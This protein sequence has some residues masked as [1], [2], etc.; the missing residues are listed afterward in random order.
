[1]FFYGLPMSEIA[2]LLYF[3]YLTSLSLDLLS[4]LSPSLD[5]PS[6]GLSTHGLSSCSSCSSC[7]S[8]CVGSPVNG[9]KCDI[10]KK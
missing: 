1:M 7:S 6:R 8:S 3:A 4:C 9:L 2:Y 5:Q 10:E